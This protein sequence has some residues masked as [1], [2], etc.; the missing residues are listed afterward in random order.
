MSFPAPGSA[1]YSANAGITPAGLTNVM[2]LATA[3]TSSTIYGP[4]GLL[5]VGQVA[6]VQNSGIY[7][8]IGFSSSSAGLSANWVELATASGDLL[9][10]TGDTGT[11]LPSAGSIKLAGTAAQIATAA[12]GSTVTF[13]LIGPYT[14][15][16]YTL[17]GV[18]YGNAANSIGA[19]AAGTSG[20]LLQSAG[21]ASS[22][23]AWTTATYPATA[24]AGALIAATATN[25]VGQIAD[26][27]VGQV[28]ASGGVG[29]IPA[30]TGSPSVSGSLT[31]ATTITATLGNITATAGNFV[32][33]T[34]GNGIV[35]NS[36][37]TSGTTT[38]TLNGR[39]GQVTITTPT[40]N[41]G[42]TFTMT[43]TN[44][45]ITGS[46]TQVLYG[47]TGGTTGSAITIQ[48]VT[49]SAGQSAVVVQNASAVTNSTGSLVLTFLVLN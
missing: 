31:A 46:T 42:A 5:L 47:L 27:A 39:S 22:P 44:S 18:L 19:T 35:L 12:S 7:Q 10:L 17:D 8:L 23:P 30:Y 28:L 9:N 43:I 49:N 13:S 34:L 38:A 37:A 16:T 45:A 14:P 29:V 32:S 11:A 25:V 48:S 1:S 15:V 24:T 33:S 3:P 4:A 2:Y 21:G 41:A 6:V 26:V 20:Q 36:G 40:I